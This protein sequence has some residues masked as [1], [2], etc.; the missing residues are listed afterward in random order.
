MSY[1]NEMRLQGEILTITT[2]YEQGVGHSDRE[3]L[4]NP[5]PE[6]SEARIAWDMG[7]EFGKSRRATPPTVLPAVVTPVPPVESFTLQEVDSAIRAFL[8]FG[9]QTFGTSHKGYFSGPGWAARCLRS[10]RESI[11]SQ[12]KAEREESEKPRSFQIGSQQ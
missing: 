11:D 10:V 5:Y 7:R 9:D 6:N 12:L 2:A 8:E 3:H 4:S 1:T